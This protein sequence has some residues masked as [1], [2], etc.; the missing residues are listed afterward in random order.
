MLNNGRP[1]LIL[2]PSRGWNSWKMA[3]LKAALKSFQERQRALERVKAREAKEEYKGKKAKS[4][5]NITSHEP[6]H[7]WSDGKRTLLPMRP[8]STVLVVGD[9]DF[10]YSRALSSL[11]SNNAQI[12]A[13]VYDDEAECHK[14]Y[15]QAAENVAALRLAPNVHSVLF[16]V[17]GGRLEALPGDV[18]QCP[19]TRIVF[20]YPHTGSGIKDRARNIRDNQD[21]L[22]AF[23]RSAADL[24]R[25]GSGAAGLS[26]TTTMAP[27][28][29][30]TTMASPAILDSDDECANHPTT[31]PP[32]VL[33]TLRTGDPYDDW[34]IKGLAKAAGLH[35][36]Q[37][38]AF[39][40]ARYPGYAHCR[41]DGGREEDFME[42]PAKT[43]VFSLRPP[44]S[45][46][47]GNT[48]SGKSG[49]TKK[50]SSK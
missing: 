47:V 32:L 15:P 21:M 49:K 45:A 36:Q 27:P 20:N 42:K 12:V 35:C 28:S 19:F 34:N 46:L 11:L 2:R 39:L 23:F 26:F 48:K 33:V 24:L 44:A 10:S 29:S 14:K 22:Q 30:T 17:D 8:D 16:R 25:T 40:A 3:K 6:V 7:V 5:Q 41:T 38:F 37:S 18:R 13:T 9:G 50:G 43:F 31:E 1:A 4:R